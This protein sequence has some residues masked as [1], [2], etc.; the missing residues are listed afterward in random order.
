MLHFVSI[1]NVIG[2]FPCSVN[3]VYKCIIARAS[4]FLGAP[5]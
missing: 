2:V 1:Y 3:I 4:A 5:I